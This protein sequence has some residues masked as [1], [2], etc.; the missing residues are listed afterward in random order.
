MMIDVIDGDVTCTE[1][2]Y[3]GL[4]VCAQKRCGGAKTRLARCS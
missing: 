3:S 2:I 4:L 1:Q